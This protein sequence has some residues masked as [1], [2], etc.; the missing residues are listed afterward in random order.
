MRIQGQLIISMRKLISKLIIYLM[1]FSTIYISIGCAHVS[2]YGPP[3]PIEEDAPPQ[4]DYP[5]EEF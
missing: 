5:E 4:S 3:E 2:P 1:I